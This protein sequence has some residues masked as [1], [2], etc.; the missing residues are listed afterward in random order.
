[1]PVNATTWSAPQP[2]RSARSTRSSVSATT[3][4]AELGRGAQQL[5]GDAGAIGLDDDADGP[6]APA[7]GWR[8]APLSASRSWRGI[9][10]T[11][12]GEHLERTR[13][14]F[15]TGRSARTRPSRSD[16]TTRVAPTRVGLAGRAPWSGAE[17]GGG[18]A[19]DAVGGDRGPARRDPPCTGR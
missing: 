6:I 14:L 11:A 9:E 5:A 8:T 2:P 10:G 1:M 17:V 15:V 7:T 18:D 16:A 3:V 12:L 19:G 13:D 4:G